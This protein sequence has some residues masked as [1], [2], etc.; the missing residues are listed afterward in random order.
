MDDDADARELV[1][2]TLESPGAVVQLASS[3]P[4]P[5]DSVSREK[6]D[7]MIAD[8]GMPQEDGYVLIQKLRAA[9]RERAPAAAPSDRSDHLRECRRPG[10]GAGLR[11]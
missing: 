6:P 3:A 7:V 2:L 9:E 11:L 4:G 10:S 5:L 8:I 1:A